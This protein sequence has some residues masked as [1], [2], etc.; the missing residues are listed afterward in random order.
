M[1][2]NIEKD[3]RNY[4][5]FIHHRGENRPPY[6][7]RQSADQLKKDVCERLRMDEWGRLHWEQLTGAPIGERTDKMLYWIVEDYIPQPV[8]FGVYKDNG[9]IY[10]DFIGSITPYDENDDNRIG[11]RPVNI[12]LYNSVP[13]V[14][15]SC[16]DIKIELV[17]RIMRTPV[18]QSFEEGDLTI[19][20]IAK[21]KAERIFEQQS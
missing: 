2:Y 19:E 18:G 5:I 7:Y 8:F 14:H 20:I 13:L 11:Y 21:D 12:L 9:L 1:D 15:P 4:Q 10:D 16:I 17:D 3:E 6:V